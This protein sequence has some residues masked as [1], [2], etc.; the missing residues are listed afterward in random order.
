MIAEDTLAPV[1]SAF[2]GWYAQFQLSD[3]AGQRQARLQGVTEL[4]K[5]ANSEMVEALV[6]LAFGTKRTASPQLIAKIREA[7]SNADANFRHS[8]NNLELQVLAAA[9]LVQI[10]EV[11]PSSSRAAL[12]ITTAA[13]GGARTV[14]LPMDLV[15]RAEI[16]VHLRAEINR[17]RPGLSMKFSKL[18]NLD[19]STVQETVQ[20][21]PDWDSVI[22]AFGEMQTVLEKTFAELAT[23]EE[24]MFEKVDSHLKIKDEELDMLWW[25]TGQR[26]T[27]LC[28]SFDA[29]QADAQPIVMGKEMADLTTLQP[30]PVSLKG[31]LSRAGL[32]ERKKIALTTSTKAVSAEW[33]KSFLNDGEYSPVTMPLHF[34]LQ[35]RLENDAGDEW[36]SNWSS[37][38]GIDANFAMSSLELGIV[39]YRERILARWP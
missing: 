24:V 12:A 5:D 19:F 35:R 16:T 36:I 31:L 18:Q 29:I 23:Q 20:S 6:R 11:G 25:L 39:F 1:K 38:T 2:T 32:K 17:K 26:S 37:V 34:A 30:G 13:C 21:R 14:E 4:A 28:C 7:F 33:S 22:A 15:A 9:C 3:D 8:G 27:D 10:M